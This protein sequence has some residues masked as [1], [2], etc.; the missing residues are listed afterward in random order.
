MLPTS[1]I[2]RLK[3]WFLKRSNCV[4]YALKKFITHKNKSYLIIRRCENHPFC[5]HWMWSDDLKD[6]NIEQ[7]TRDDSQE[8]NWMEKI[9]YEGY[10]KKGDD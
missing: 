6:A 9:Y 5:L 1:V 7:Y 8:L 4:L 3:N 10:V 2:Q